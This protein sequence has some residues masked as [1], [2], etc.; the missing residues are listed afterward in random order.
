MLKKL[1]IN[2]PFTNDLKEMPSYVKF[3][4]E[5]LSNKRTLD[6]CHMVSMNRECR[7]PPKLQDPSSFCIPINVGAHPYNALCDLGAGVSLLLLSMCEKIG[8]KELKPV[9]MQLYMENRSIA[10]PI[11]I[12]EDIP[13]RVRK[14]YVPIDFLVLD[15]KANSL[16]PIIFGRPFLAITG[17]M[18]N[19]KEWILPF[20]I[21]DEKIEFNFAKSV[22]SPSFEDCYDR[23]DIVDMEAQE[24][25]M[26]I[27]SNDPLELCLTT[28]YQGRNLA[29]AIAD[30]EVSPEAPELG[31]VAPEVPLG[32]PDVP[33]LELKPLPST[34]RYEFL[35]PN[36]TY[37]VIVNAKLNDDEV[38]R[39]LVIIRNH[40]RALGYS[41]DDLKGI[42][43]SLFMHRTFMED[44]HKPTI[45]HQKRL[46][47][48]LKEVVKKEIIKLLDA[49]INFPISDSK[50]VSLVHVVRKKGGLTVIKNENDELI[51]TKSITGWRMCID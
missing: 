26:S 16:I 50:W 29:S 27:I 38:E 2:I 6:E 8:I 42:S 34:L 1:Y 7:L 43:P 23:I 17:T 48:N 46:N 32:E 39:L 20:T 47:P 30:L 49:R 35:G 9:K 40:K 15:I 31:K 10:H 19:V 21:G 51:P 14:Y 11:G 25:L 36:S 18:I 37:P 22:K 4:K 13:I 24:Y 45:E 3:L 44:N 41:S 12:L 5:T 28:T 33:K